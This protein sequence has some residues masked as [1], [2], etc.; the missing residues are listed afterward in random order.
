[1]KGLPFC[2]FHYK[3]N[4]IIDFFSSE[5]SLVFYKRSV[6][7]EPTGATRMHYST[8]MVRK[9]DGNHDCV[10]YSSY[11]YQFHSD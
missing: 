5:E 11:D 4:V 6:T 3:R 10:A 7:A 8:E 1:M 9:R 2:H